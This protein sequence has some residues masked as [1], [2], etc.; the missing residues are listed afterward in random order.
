MNKNVTI[1]KKFMGP[2]GMAN[3]GYVAGLMA[4]PF[5]GAVTVRLHRPVPLERPLALHNGNGW[6]LTEGEA[7]I[8]SARADTFALNLPDLPAFA[9]VAAVATGYADASQHPFQHCFVCGPSRKPH[10][11]LCIFPTRLPGRNMVAA[12][13]Q[14]YPTLAAETGFVQT[15][16][17]WAALDCPGG[18]ATIGNEPRPLVLGQISG[19]LYGR[20]RADEKVMVLGWPIEANGRKHTVG[21]ALLAES[22]ILLGKALAIW[23]EL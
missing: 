19:E 20:V 16:Y 7:L 12:L 11:G 17:L 8:A 13:W 5:A 9:E 22:G 1:S 2:P 15:Q 6:Q 21:T 23:L 14:P 3:G 18:I 4:R 10:D